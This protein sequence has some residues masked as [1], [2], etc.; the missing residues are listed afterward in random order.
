M[1]ASQ[2]RVRRRFATAIP[3]NPGMNTSITTTSG[4]VSAI[5][6]MTAFAF[7]VMPTTS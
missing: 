4:A 7:A 5:A 6:L 2:P 1:T 3:L